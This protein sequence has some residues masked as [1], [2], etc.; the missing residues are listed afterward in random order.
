[1][2]QQVLVHDTIWCNRRQYTKPNAVGARTTHGGD[3]TWNIC[4]SRSNGLIVRSF[5]WRG[6]SLHTWKLV[7]TF[8]GSRENVFDMYGDSRENLLEISTA[9][10]FWSL[11]SSV[12]GMTQ[13]APVYIKTATG[14]CIQTKHE[15][16]PQQASENKMPQA[17]EGQFPL[18]MLH[19]R[20][21]PNR[22]AQITRYRAV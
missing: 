11:I 17:P 2:T 15:R 22:E 10:F 20:N 9:Y 16:H 14:A 3:Q 7:W 5:E 18:K 6:L 1:M 12:C 4:I 8:G 19:S 21:A 13:Q